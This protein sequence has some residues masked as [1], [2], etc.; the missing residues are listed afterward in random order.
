M[1]FWKGQSSC[2]VAAAVALVAGLAGTAQAHSEIKRAVALVH[3]TKGSQVQ[4]TVTFSK[5]A[6][7]LR[8]QAEIRGLAPG[9]HGFHIHEFGDC[10]A[11]DASS[12]GGHFDPAHA[13]HGAPEAA[14]RHVGDL[15]NLEA[16][17]SGMARLDRVDPK[18]S[19]DGESSVLGRGVIVHTSED[20]FR[21]QPTGNA[22]A[23]L[24]CGV[25]GL[26]KP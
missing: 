8:I 2:A 13:A 23:R 15:G 4:G 17:A 12:A 14:A 26:A 24:G 20:D 10:T 25:V 1:E 18:A 5:V 21:T 3:P 7:G 11:E 6:G 22:G 9:K 19:L 16:D